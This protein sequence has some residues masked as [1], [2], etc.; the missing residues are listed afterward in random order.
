[1]LPSAAVPPVPSLKEQLVRESCSMVRHLVTNG[2][3]VPPSV[4]NAVEEFETALENGRRIDMTALSGA[5]ERL[6]RLVAPAKPGLHILKVVMGQDGL[7]FE[8]AGQ[9]GLHYNVTIR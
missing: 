5:H 4:V 2:V 7:D 1:M 9:A 3:R 6:A 8:A